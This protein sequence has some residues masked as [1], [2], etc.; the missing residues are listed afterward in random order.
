MVADNKEVL[1]LLKTA[2]GQI[3][4]IIKMVNN[5]KYCIDIYTQILATNAVLNKANKEIIGAHMKSCVIEAIDKGQ[6]DEKIE[7]IIQLLDKLVK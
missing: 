2:R 5:D 1:R 4:G 3:D 6:G 7:E